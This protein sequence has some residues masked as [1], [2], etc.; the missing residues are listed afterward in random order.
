MPRNFTKIFYGTEERSWAL[1]A[2]GGSPEEGTTHQGA[3]EAQAPPGGL[4]PPW[5]PPDRLFA[6]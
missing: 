2:S 1:V 6:I 4:W 5:V 3:Q